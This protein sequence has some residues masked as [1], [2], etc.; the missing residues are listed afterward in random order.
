M[1]VALSYP[2]GVRLY[3]HVGRILSD[4]VIQ[5]ISMVFPFNIVDHHNRSTVTTALSPIQPDEAAQCPLSRIKKHSSLVYLLVPLTPQ[6]P[7][8]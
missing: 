2:S 3:Y 4:F 8:P 5:L 1:T 6:F 7:Y